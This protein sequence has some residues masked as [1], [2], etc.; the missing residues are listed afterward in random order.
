[1]IILIPPKCSLENLLNLIKNEMKDKT[2]NIEV[3]YQVE[4]AT[5]PMKMVTSSSVLF[6]LEMKKR[7]A[8]KITDL[9]L[10]VT[11]VQ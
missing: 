1:M 10:C 2:T 5:P 11:V 9:P 8:T 4:K 7:Y 6:F 3:S